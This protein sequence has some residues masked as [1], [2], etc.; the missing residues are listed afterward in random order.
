[1]SHKS[2]DSESRNNS[3]D[4]V[5]MIT[6]RIGKITGLILA[7]VGLLA[8]IENS[9]KIG[10][11]ILEKFKSEDSGKS[12][13]QAT[14]KYPNRVSVSKWGKMRISLEGSNECSERLAVHVVFKARQLA[15]VKVSSPFLDCPKPGDF[16]PGCWEQKSIETGKVNAT[17]M[18]PHL[19]VLKKPLGE[20][21]EIYI[22][23][24][25]YNVNTKEQLYAGIAKIELEDDS[26]SD[27]GAT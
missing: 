5:G 10:S 11:T 2:K 15:K 12:C 3:I 22:N 16:G 13:F 19:E 24:I 6:G 1:M 21:V 18:A 8:A 14:M 27:N 20:P 4:F 9:F 25:V 23:W 17:F 26:D 7:L